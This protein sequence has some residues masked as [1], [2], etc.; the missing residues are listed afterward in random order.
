MESASNDPMAVFLTIGLIHLIVNQDLS[1]LMLLLMFV[2]QMSLGVFLGYI[3][4]K[5]LVLGINH[6][7][8][9]YKGL[10]SCFNTII[11]FINLWGY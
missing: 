10:I 5:L 11:C 9:E 8:L 2:Q 1:I 6:L 7:K 4:G 3:L